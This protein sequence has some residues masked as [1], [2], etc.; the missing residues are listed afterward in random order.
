MQ[1]IAPAFRRAEE[2]H[3][4]KV[5]IL[6]RAALDGRKRCGTFAHLFERFRHVLVRDVHRGHV[7]LQ[8]LVITQFEFRQ[9]FEDR[10]ELQR[11]ALVEI[12]LIH[13]RLRNWGEFL[14][15]HGFFHALRH[16]RLQHF[17]LDVIC[18]LAANQ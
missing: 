7:E 10:A 2:F 13:L 5:A 12:Q 17:S 9:H 16:Q 8:A 11:L 15:G 1:R 4:S 14:F 18:E 6:N 3:L